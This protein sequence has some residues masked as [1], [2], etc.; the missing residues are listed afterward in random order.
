MAIEI[1][2]SKTGKN[3]GHIAIVDDCD[4]IL[5]ELNWQVQKNKNLLY[6]YRTTG[7]RKAVKNQKMHREVM[8]RMMGKPLEK[9]QQV[10]HINGNGL[11]NR[12]ENLRIATR[13][14]N[15]ANSR[16][17]V[18]NTSGFKGVSKAKRKG[19]W[20]ARLA[21]D[22]KEKTV[23]Y[24]DNPKDAWDARNI[25]GRELFGDFWNDGS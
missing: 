24:F 7:G 3:K 1:P 6:A 18:D 19:K 17:R 25:L 5:A 16:K 20:R 11:D 22:G 21:V 13:V 8:E 10:D 4:E 2:L 12:R 15:M 14:Q 9:W 23:G